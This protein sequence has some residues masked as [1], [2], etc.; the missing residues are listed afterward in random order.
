MGVPRRAIARYIGAEAPRVK[1]R[2]ASTLGHVPTVFSRIIAGELPGTFVWRDDSC[3]AFCSI[4]PM[5]PGHTLVVPRLEVD[6]WIDLDADLAQHLF[7]V[8][9]TIGRAQQRAFSRRRIGVMIVGDEVP[10]VHVHVV[11]ID[12][13]GELSFA[14]ADRSPPPGSI[15]EAARRLRGALEELG[16]AGVSE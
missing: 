7:A 10:H 8:A 13:A 15:D 2:N 3:V 4:E 16:A 12:T 6:H 11:P 1:R 5:N 14:H 9:Q